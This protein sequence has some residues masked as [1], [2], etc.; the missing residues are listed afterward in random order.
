MPDDDLFGFLAAKRPGLAAATDPVE[1]LETYDRF[2]EELQS[3]AGSTNEAV[4]H[5][6][7]EHG[8]FYRRVQQRVLEL[9]EFADAEV[10]LAD[11][12]APHK[13]QVERFSSGSRPTP[14]HGSRISRASPTFRRCV[15]SWLPGA[16]RFP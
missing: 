11:A 1:F 5:S 2:L 13:A 15:E 16:A 3:F 6:V 12:D 9:R 10:L 4:E 14:T 7:Q 8:P